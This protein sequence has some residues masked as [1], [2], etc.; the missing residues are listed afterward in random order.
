VDALQR[1]LNDAAMKLG[2]SDKRV[3]WKLAHR[4][5]TAR[6][7]LNADNLQG[8]R[9]RGVAAVLLGSRGS[10]GKSAYRIFFGGIEETRRVAMKLPSPEKFEAAYARS[11]AAAANLFRWVKLAPELTE[12]VRRV[13]AAD[14]WNS[15]AVDAVDGPSGAGSSG[16]GT[17]GAGTSGAGTSASSTKPDCPDLFDGG[18]LSGITLTE[19]N[20]A[21]AVGRLAAIKDINALRLHTERLAVQIVDRTAG[22]PSAAARI[23]GVAVKAQPD[24][25]A[26]IVAEVKARAPQAFGK[27]FAA[28]LS[29]GVLNDS[30]TLNALFSLHAVTHQDLQSLSAPQ[31]LHYVGLLAVLHE[32]AA[33][34]GDASNEVIGALETGLASDAASAAESAM[35]LI[36]QLNRASPAGANALLDR[37]LRV[38]KAQD[39]G[40]TAELFRTGLKERL[41]EDPDRIAI[42]IAVAGADINALLPVEADRNRVVG[43]AAIRHPDAATRG[44]FVDA[45][46]V[47]YRAALAR[48]PPNYGYCVSDI[49]ALARL[50]PKRAG[51][52]ARRLIEGITDVGAR[53]VA[54]R[55]LTRRPMYAAPTFFA[56]F[57]GDRADERQVRYD[58]IFGPVRD[59]FPNTA[60]EI[61]ER[62]QLAVDALK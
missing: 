58:R 29:E 54:L 21:E 16:A 48:T 4:R 45:L 41:F 2:E 1:A 18:W 6:A 28:L 31:K 7:P 51:T 27:L 15:A 46:L 57:M 42:A 60:R 17:S 22:D 32:S 13:S 20:A 30:A 52:I 39:Q 36:R 3:A 49:E 59:Q 38:A 44:Q 23:V 50:S 10:S 37:I 62:H 24:M 25:G 8:S 33:V 35:K 53:A 34:R 55:A 40:A 26:A 11:P 9:T 12:F 5:G 14:V 56:G 47:A 61:L 19:A 43:L